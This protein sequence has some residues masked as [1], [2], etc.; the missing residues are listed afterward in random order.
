[1]ARGP[2]ETHPTSRGTAVLG[3]GLR[4][5]G[6]VRGDGDLRVEADVE[7]DIAVTGTLQIDEA[8]NV[9]GAVQ[10]DTVVVAG[11]LQ[12]DALARTAI[13]IVASGRVQGSVTAPAFSLEEGGGLEGRIEADF[14]LPKG[15][16]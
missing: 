2:A 9:T 8:A 15:L 11:Q 6:R 3:K 16:A 5:V 4:V 1:M 14:E 7:G 12:G 13:T 10:A